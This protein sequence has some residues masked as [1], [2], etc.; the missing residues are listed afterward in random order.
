MQVLSYF[1]YTKEAEKINV[2]VQKAYLIGGIE[3]LAF[4]IETLFMR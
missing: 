2:S 1:A 3:T 4:L